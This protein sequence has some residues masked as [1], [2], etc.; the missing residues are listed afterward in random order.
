MKLA[1]LQ[2]ADGVIILNK[3]TIELNGESAPIKDWRKAVAWL[4]ENDKKFE[5]HV[6]A[7]PPVPF[8]PSNKPEW[9]ALQEHSSHNKK[10]GH[11]YHIKG[12]TQDV[13]KRIETLKKHYSSYR[14]SESRTYDKR[15]SPVKWGVSWTSIVFYP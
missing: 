6:V 7:C 1:D 8:K 2:N 15:E 5:N 4:N 11:F 13:A 9:H 3:F 12:P 14:V 10:G